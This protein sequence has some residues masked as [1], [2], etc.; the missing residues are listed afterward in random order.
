MWWNE[1]KVKY[2]LD[3]DLFR[4]GIFLKCVYVAAYKELEPIH[5]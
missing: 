3:F 4:S 5:E 1:T 2:A